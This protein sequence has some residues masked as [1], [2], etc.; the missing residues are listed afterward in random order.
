MNKFVLCTALFLLHVLP[1]VFA[2]FSM[3]IY[4]SGY[5]SSSDVDSDTNEEPGI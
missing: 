2:D 4:E 1:F 5:T 3:M